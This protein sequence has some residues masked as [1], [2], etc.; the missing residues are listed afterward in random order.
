MTNQEKID[1]LTA[2]I[3]ELEISII[4][5][6]L[7]ALMGNVVKD[8]VRLDVMKLNLVNLQNNEG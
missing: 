8:K 1:F 5:D 2:K 4:K 3:K 7:Q 6:E